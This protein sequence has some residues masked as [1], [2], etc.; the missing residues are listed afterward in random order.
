M[1]TQYTTMHFSQARI[2]EFSSQGGGGGVPFPE[3]FDNLPPPPEKKGRGEKTERFGYSI[4]LS[5]LQK[6]GLNR[7]SK[8]VYCR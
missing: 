4:P 5:L 7:L 8:Q 3:I 6:Y 2:Q 1:Y